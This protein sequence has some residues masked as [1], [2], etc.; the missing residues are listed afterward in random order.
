M[1]NNIQVT[2]KPTS[3]ELTVVRYESDYCNLQAYVKIVNVKSVSVTAL[4][5]KHGSTNQ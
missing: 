2:Y 4:K 5:S 3:S 1:N